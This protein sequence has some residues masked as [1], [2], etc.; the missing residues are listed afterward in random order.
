MIA[1]RTRKLFQKIL[2]DILKF[3]IP[4]IISVGLCWILFRNDS[5]ADMV[6][7]VRSKCDFTWIGLMLLVSFFSFIFRALRWGLQLEGVGIKAS[8]GDLVLSIFGTYAV[9]LVFPRLG[10]VW[11]SGYIAHREDAPFGTVMGTM[12]ADRFADLLTAVLFLVVTLIV[13]HQAILAFVH[14]YPEGY[15]HL[16]LI[17][18]SPWTWVAVVMLVAVAV[19]FFTMKSQNRFV[20]MVRNFCAQMWNGFAAI[21]TMKHK[22]QWLLWTLLLWSCYLGQMVLAFHAFPFTRSIFEADGFTPVLV[23]F[24]LGTIAMG[25]P[26]NGGIGPY[27]IALIFGL[28]L[29]EPASLDSAASKIFDLDSKAFANTVLGMSTC[30]TIFLGLVTF[31][32]IAM[33]N[34][35]HSRANHKSPFDKEC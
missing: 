13:G 21:L 3:I 18:T 20:N 24:T 14:Q 10:E 22:G 7:V 9:N 17:V 35:R 11:R 8:K 23:C 29:Y 16:E 30:L 5:L 2:G 25:I 4:L 12:I 31:I 27:Q 1:K 28:C 34:R 32:T 26:S 33:R 19:W 6:E 15:R